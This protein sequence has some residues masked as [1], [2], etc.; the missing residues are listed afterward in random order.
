[1]NRKD[2]YLGPLHIIVRGYK[3]NSQYGAL[4]WGR[5]IRSTTLDIWFNKTLITFTRDKYR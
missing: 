1:M 2:W 4:L 3:E 5:K